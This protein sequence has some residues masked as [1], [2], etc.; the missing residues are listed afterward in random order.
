LRLEQLKYA[1]GK[2]LVN[3]VLLAQA[4]L[5]QVQVGYYTALRDYGVAQAAL[6]RAIGRTASRRTAQ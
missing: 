6:R 2:G 5:L 4:K 1:N 3:D